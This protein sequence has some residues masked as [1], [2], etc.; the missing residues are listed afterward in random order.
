[1]CKAHVGGFIVD[2]QKEKIP[3][4]MLSKRANYIRDLYIRAKIQMRLFEKEG[5]KITFYLRDGQE[6]IVGASHFIKAVDDAMNAMPTHLRYVLKK[7]L[8][9]AKDY[10]HYW[11]MET[12]SRSTYYRQRKEAYRQFVFLL[13]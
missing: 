6:E 4:V 1:M 5:E 11:Y 13:G 7:E 9:E 2:N 3:F 10:E 12:L 8:F